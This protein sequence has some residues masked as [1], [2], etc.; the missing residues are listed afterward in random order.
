VIEGMSQETFDENR[1]AIL[2]WR[3]LTPLGARAVALGRSWWCPRSPSP[4]P[5]RWPT[6]N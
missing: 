6:D 2:A 1:A 5:S 3:H 4:R